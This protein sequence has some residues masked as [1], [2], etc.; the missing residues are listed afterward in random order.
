MLSRRRFITGASLAVVSLS[1]VPTRAQ[2]QDRNFGWL[3]A[4]KSWRVLAREPEWI[5][6]YEN[7]VATMKARRPA[8]PTS[9]QFQANMHGSIAGEHP[10]FNKC[11]HRNWLFL[12][13]HR[14][15][16]YYFEQI[17]SSTGNGVNLPYW[18]YTNPMTRSIPIAFLQKTSPLYEPSRE[19]N[20]GSP[21]SEDA[22]GQA[23]MVQCLKPRNFAPTPIRQ[24]SFGGDGNG[25]GTVER[26]PHNQVHVEIGGKM[27][28]P[29]TAAQDPIFWLHHANID[30]LWEEWL[31]LGNGRSNPTDNG[32]LNTQFR[33]FDA[34]GKQVVHS[35]R[36]A[37]E[38]SKLGY[39][40]APDGERTLAAANEGKEAFVNR[41]ML[42]QA[43]ALYDIGAK[44]IT[45]SLPIAE[46][47][48]QKFAAA[49]G[50]NEAAFELSLQGIEIN[51]LPTGVIR[52]FLN[53]PDASRSTSIDDLHYAGS[54]AFF[55]TTKGRHAHG[56]KFSDT[57]DV[58]DAVQRLQR[59]GALQ[60]T[61]IQVTLVST[62]D[63]DVKT[64]EVNLAAIEP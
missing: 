14:L 47:S 33:F 8:D 35:V 36:D 3:R 9:W 44:P 50:N 58:T 11:E 48:R 63:D 54:F 23:A 56:D 28:D 2:D 46:N 15:Y 64:H 12:P 10:L 27:G 29:A 13:W 60:G 39:R 55:G 57:L 24:V 25:N 37:L 49:A 19:L 52:V 31:K 20:D 41:S 61:A 22:V 45:V 16:I 1:S 17:L 42:A 62:K 43:P 34:D 59:N 7:A 5:V 21:L 32:W 51:R 30:R 4:R 53:K 38:T 40:Y 26:K 18:D 6:R